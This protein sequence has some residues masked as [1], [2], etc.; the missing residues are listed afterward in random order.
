MGLASG[1]RLGPYEIRSALGAGGMGEVYRACDTRLGRD[2]AIKILPES[3]ARDGDR[4][5]RFELEARTVAALNHPNILA[6]FDIGTH[7]GSPYIVSELLEGQTLRQRLEEGPLPSRRAVEF[8]LQVSQGLAAAHEKG[9]VH[10]DMKPENIFLTKDGRVK[11]LD[12]G[13]AKLARLEGASGSD[14]PTLGTNQ[15]AAGM[16][17]GTVGYMS[18][19]QVRGKPIDPRSDIFSFGAVVYEMLAGKRAFQG[20]TSADTLTAILQ[21][22]PPELTQSGLQVSP[23]LDRIVRRCLEKEASDRFQGARDLGYALDAVMGSSAPTAEAPAVEVRKKTPNLRLL[24][25]VTSLVAVLALAAVAWLLT[26]RAPPPLD[27]AALTFRRGNIN[28]ARFA[29]DGQTVVYSAAWD[30]APPEIFSVRKSLTDS[31]TLLADATLMAVSNTGELAVIAQPKFLDWNS[32]LGTV[33]SLSMA[34]GRPREI[35][36]NIREADWS[37]EG[38]GLAVVRMVGRECQVEFPLGKPLFRT[39][40]YISDLRFS[41]DGRRLAFLHHPIDGDDRGDVVVVDLQGRATTVSANWESTQGLAWSA[42]GQE[43]W[44][45]AATTGGRYSIHAATLSGK[46]REILRAPA[47]VRI[48]DVAPDGRMLITRDDMRSGIVAVTPDG[49]EHDFSW[50]DFAGDPIISRDGATVIFTDWSEAAGRDY[51]PNLRKLD[52][53]P[54]IQLGNGVAEGISDDGK[55]MLAL[56]PGPPSRL[57]LLPTGAGQPREFPKGSIDG[58]NAKGSWFHDGKRVA[59]NAHLPGKPSQ[60][61]L[62]DLSGGDPRPISPEALVSVQAGISPDDAQILAYT[63]ERTL[64]LAP[65]SGGPP[66]PVAGVRADD[67]PAGWSTDPAHLYVVVTGTLHPELYQVNVLTGERKLLRRI[68]PADT[69][70]LYP[71]RANFTV[72]ADGRTLAYEYDRSLDQLFIAEPSR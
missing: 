63:A 29:P 61:F 51:A 26:R 34:G 42:D 36:E 62:Q 14:S 52:G 15:T 70:G 2:V 55:W 54:A 24:L 58:Y 44:F 22:D 3:F 4:L 59:F 1:T 43:V 12:F 6:L 50:G 32:A 45:S 56:L 8:A 60:V 10:R 16:V 33:G 66:R 72:A 38:A 57:M 5:H 47:R 20:E 41:R 68:S 65:I 9:V 27:Y 7:D 48:Q 46:V 39:S 25:A 23:A 49:K 30:G 71:F 69:A 19:E 21:Q 64:V 35:L 18:P 31:R 53:S 67:S 11:I 40:G 37:P 17:M 13:L 28:R